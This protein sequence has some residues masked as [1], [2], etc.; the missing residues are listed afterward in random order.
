MKTQTSLILNP[1]CKTRKIKTR[2]RH[3]QDKNLIKIDYKN[4]TRTKQSCDKKMYPKLVLNKLK[5]IKGPTSTY[6]PCG[7][8]SRKPPWKFCVWPMS[9]DVARDKTKNELN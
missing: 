9:I 6:T 3:V 1:N 2:T 7:L 5:V 4:E 8:N